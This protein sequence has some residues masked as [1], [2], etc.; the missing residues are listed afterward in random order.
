MR[1][2]V[3]LEVVVLMAKATKQTHVVYLSDAAPSNNAMELF[4]SE[5]GQSF[6]LYSQEAYYDATLRKL[7]NENQ[8]TTPGPSKEKL[9][10]LGSVW[11]APT[12]DSSSHLEI[13]RS[14]LHLKGVAIDEPQSV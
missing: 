1:T 7:R 13:S 10:L 9:V 14:T 8:L 3:T 2:D 12:F 11:G 4:V 5:S 6:A